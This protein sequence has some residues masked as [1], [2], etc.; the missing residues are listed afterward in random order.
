VSVEQN[1]TDGHKAFSLSGTRLAFPTIADYQV[2][3]DN[4]TSAAEKSLLTTINAF[5]NFTS[6]N[7]KFV[8]DTLIKN[9]LFSTILNG[10]GVVQ[11]GANIF[12]VD[13]T[14]AKVFVLPVADIAYYN[15]LIA[16][17]PQSGKVYMFSTNDNVLEQ[18][19]AGALNQAV[20]SIVDLLPLSGAKGKYSIKIRIPPIVCEEGGIG[21]K[22]IPTKQITIANAKAMTMRGYLN[23]NNSGIYYSLWADVYTDFSGVVDLSI[24]LEP[25]YYHVRCNNT[26]G[27]Y[28]TYGYGAGNLTSEK[29]FQSY[30][31][32]A[33]LN[34]VR[35]RGRFHGTVYLPT[36]P[37]TTDTEWIELR[38]NY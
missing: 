6:W 16:T 22:K 32:S 14:Y 38:V 11:I 12:R 21:D 19:A 29:K 10:D 23:F 26:V 37:F 2:A 1:P 15:D 36:G 7:E 24:D 18:I 9:T 34:Q 8:K 3:V 13:K 28:N 30:Q 25:V 35:L 17:Y 4:P 20:V 33:N 31:G 5:S 27:P